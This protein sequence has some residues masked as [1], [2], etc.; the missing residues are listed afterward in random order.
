MAS[1]F[2][3]YLSGALTA[4]VVQ[5]VLCPRSVKGRVV[6]QVP[7]ICRRSLVSLGNQSSPHPAS[8]GAEVRNHV[9]GSSAVNGQSG[10]GHGHLDQLLVGPLRGK[11]RHCGGRKVRGIV[12]C[13]VTKVERHQLQRKRS[14]RQD[15]FWHQH[16]GVGLSGVQPASQLKKHSQRGP[17]EGALCNSE[18]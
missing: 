14:L 7:G 8:P 18:V 16:R 6:L 17:A 10:S 15:I 9:D 12:S 11:A 13:H 2:F 4:G 1:E 5:R 3:Q